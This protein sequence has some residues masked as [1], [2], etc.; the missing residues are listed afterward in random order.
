[1]VEEGREGC[2]KTRNNKR[3]RLPIIGEG[4]ERKVMI[5]IEEKIKNTSKQGARVPG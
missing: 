3:E 4:C 1:M 5:G 2:T